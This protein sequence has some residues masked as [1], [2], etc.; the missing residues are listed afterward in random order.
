MYL[1]ISVIVLAMNSSNSKFPAADRIF[2]IM[3]LLLAISY[4]LW[5]ATQLI[6][7][8]YVDIWRMEAFIAYLLIVFP[9]TFLIPNNSPQDTMCALK[10]TVYNV[11][12]AKHWIGFYQIQWL[13]SIYPFAAS[14]RIIHML[15]SASH[16]GHNSHQNNNKTLQCSRIFG[17]DYL[18]LHICIHT[19]TLLGNTCYVDTLDQ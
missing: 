16:H 15:F 5:L 4:T 10:F 7:L 8:H 19:Y 14:T 12:S 11:W 1:W 9:W 2:G 6:V 13:H 18:Y 17:K 3:M